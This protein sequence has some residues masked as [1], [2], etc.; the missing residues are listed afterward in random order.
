MV[1][2]NDKARLDISIKSNRSRFPNRIE[3][4]PTKNKTITQNQKE[5][6]CFKLL[7]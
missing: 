7:N 5:L 1:F 6:D 4:L 2:Q 3:K